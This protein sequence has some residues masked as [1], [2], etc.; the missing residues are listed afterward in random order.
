MKARLLIIGGSEDREAR[1]A[2]LERFVELVGGAASRIVVPT[3]ASRA[4]DKLWALYDAAFGALGVRTRPLQIDIASRACANDAAMAAGV[5]AADSIFITGGDQKR[6]LA[7]VGGTAL[8]AA[9]QEALAR[10]A[11][12][13]GT[14]A[15]ASAMSAH[16]LAS[17]RGR[18]TPEKGSVGLGAGFGFVQGV[19]VDQHFSQRHRLARLLA[20]VAQNPYL[21]GIGIG[22]DEDTA[23]LIEQ[24]R[25][26]EII[27]SGTVTILDGR[28]MVSNVA[29]VRNPAGRFSQYRHKDR[30][31]MKTLEQRILR[32]PNLFARR[33]CVQ[34]LADLGELAW[35]ATLDLPG[36]DQDLL[37]LLPGLRD[38]EPPPLHGALIAEVIGRVALELQRIAGAEP[39]VPFS[40]VVRCQQARVKIVVSYQ[41]EMV[42]VLALGSAMAIVGSLCAG[43]K[44]ALN[45]YLEALH[46]SAQQ[47]AVGTSTAA[48]VSAAAWSGI[49]VFRITDQA[50][51]FQLGWGSRQKRLHATMTGDTSHVMVGIAGDRQLTKSLLEQGGIPVPKGGVAASVQEALAMAARLR[52]PVTLKPL[53]GNQGKGVSTGC[54]DEQ[55]VAAAFDFARQHGRKIIVE[56]HI[57]GR[58]YR[59]LVAGAKVAA[60]ALR[61]P[62]CVRGDGVSSVQ[63]LVDTE[64]LDPVRGVGHDNILTRIRIDDHAVALLRAQGFESA[65]IVP[66]GRQVQLRSNANLSTGGTAEDVTDL[67]HPATAQ[68]CIRAARLTGLDVAGLDLVCA[69]I[70]QPLRAQGGA[71][72]EVNAAPGIRIHEFPSKGSGRPAGDAIVEA[73]FGRGDGRI[74]VIAV[75]G[76]NGK[77]TTA[78][79]IAHCTGLAGMNTGVTT[80]EGV[81]INGERII[82]GDCAG[83][84]S[85]RVLLAS[86]EVDIAV[87]ETAR[88]G[89]LKRGLAFDRC[90]VAVVLNVSNDH[91]GLDGIDTVEDLARVKAVVAR[92]AAD[93]VVL[94][95]DDRHCLLMETYIEADVERIYFSMEP[96]NP[97][98]LHHLKKGG[99]AAYF[100][101]NALIVADGARRSEVIKA[102]CMPA[103]IG[104][105][106]RHNVANAL[107]AAAALMGAGFTQAQISAGLSTFV[108]DHAGNPL[109]SNIYSARGVTIVVDYA[110]NSAAYEAIGAMAKG[111]STG[112]CVAVVTGPGD[113]RDADLHDIGRA[114]ARDFDE[115]FVYEADPRGRASG[116][117][118]DTILAGARAAGKDEALLHA[119]VPVSDAFS[120]AMQSCRPGDV[121]V[122]A[123]GSAETAQRETARYIDE[124]A[125]EAR[126]GSRIGSLA[127]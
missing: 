73:M 35:V 45:E 66:Q 16:M 47:G 14:S 17:G 63:Q 29:D 56:R 61:R 118:A 32:G 112:R 71:I 121:L 127:R 98:L 44:I 12:V 109:R 77:T 25:A 9:M 102:W 60:A 58:D 57:E 67:L 111:L 42:G 19:I 87:L 51:L 49:P 43:K 95:A 52:Y 103:A 28:N 85:A 108:S 96:E 80:T 116:A 99:R 4:G 34:T 105:H 92:A 72:I 78:L 20:V 48:V 46:A 30:L 107:A 22:I 23:L 123:C 31:I 79:M 62:P 64:N 54:R 82:E 38:V 5:A 122:F 125:R 94:N 7:L 117:T 113:R 86:P 90:N 40:T 55:E 76:T 74:P 119:V 124:P 18:L 41:L 70:A 59:V 88:G 100:Q 110:H 2:V 37:A 33:P 39:D 75:T 21:I 69:D 10:G 65:S 97:V 89:I 36:F 120:A 91:L 114:C 84:H 68:M 106:A 26:I 115:L 101:D 13:A 11:C 104:G 15:G 53:N 50:N 81:Y 6:L 24:Q 93:A 1:K 3:A 83:Y 126:S 8:D 27:G